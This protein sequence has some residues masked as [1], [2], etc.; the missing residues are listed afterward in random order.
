MHGLVMLDDAGDVVRPALLWNDGRA[1]AECEAVRQSV[2]GLDRLVALTGNDAFAGFTLPKLLWVRA[3]EPEAYARTAQVLLPKDYVRY[4]LTGGY[5]TDRA[6]AG[7]TLYA[8]PGVARLVRRRARR[9]RRAAR[10]A[11]ADA[12][13]AG[14]HG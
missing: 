2:G 1:Q 11:P 6:G 8:R 12:R 13:G 9:A 14:G 3:H 5:A 4:R 10:V 7:G